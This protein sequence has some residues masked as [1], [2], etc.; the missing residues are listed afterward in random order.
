M[1]GVEP[2]RDRISMYS[3]CRQSIPMT[4]APLLTAACHA[5]GLDALERRLPDGKRRLAGRR[6]GVSLAIGAVE[7]R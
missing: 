4:C 2:A 5:H 6:L 1:I 7:V 3:G